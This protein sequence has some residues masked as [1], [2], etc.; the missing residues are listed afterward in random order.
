MEIPINVL[1]SNPCFL[2]FNQSCV[3]NLG[4]LLIR[5]CRKQ[6]KLH[7]PYCFL[8]WQRI[9]APETR[10]HM[11]AEENNGRLLVFRIRSTLNHSTNISHFS[12]LAPSCHFP[13]CSTH[14]ELRAQ[15]YTRKVTDSIRE[16]LTRLIWLLLCASICLQWWGNCV[17]HGQQ[18]REDR[19]RH[20]ETE[21]DSFPY[22]SALRSRPELQTQTPPAW[23][24]RLAWKQ[25]P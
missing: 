25:I 23:T 2:A 18:T 3:I 15:A 1:S 24:C 19:K 9:W 17:P 12:L 6:S 8:T 14:P 13:S 16:I 11:S 10:L 20:G 5:L 7:L 22:I 21:E 4:T